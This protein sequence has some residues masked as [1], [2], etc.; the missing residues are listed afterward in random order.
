MEEEKILQQIKINKLEQF[1]EDFII[2]QLCVLNNKPFNEMKKV[3]DKLILQKRIFIKD[4]AV[5]DVMRDSSRK[6]VILK[7]NKG[8]VIKS[9]K[10]KGSKNR[11]DGKIAGTKKG[12]AFLVPF[13]SSAKD[14]FISEKNLN[15]AVNNDKV[16]IEILTDRK[17]RE[18]RVVQI[19]ERGNGS[20]VGKIKLGKVNAYVTPDDVKFG[21]DIF[22]PM[23]K[24]LGASD[25]DKVL[26]KVERYYSDRKLPDG[27][28]VE[29]L[30]PENDIKVQVL[31]CLRNYG[32][33]EGFPKKV[34]AAAIE[35][36]TIVDEKKYPH[37]KDR[38]NELIFTIDGADTRD[39]DDAIGLKKLKNG[40]YLLGVYIADVGEYVTR[41]RIIEDEAFKRGNSV[42]FPGLVLPML[43]KELSNG[44]CSLNPNVDR[45][46]LSVEMEIDKNGD[47]VN[48]DIFEGI[49]RSNKQFTYHEVQK[50]LDK[51]EN[52][53]KENSKFIETLWLMNELSKIL[54]NKRIQRGEITLDLPEAQIVLTETGDVSDI[55][56]QAHDDAHKLIESFMIA[57]NETIAT[58]YFL[59]KAPF[60]YRVHEKPDAE[61]V[62]NFIRIA[63][64]YGVKCN[65]SGENVVPKNLQKAL[66]QINGQDFA[67][68]L[69]RICLRSQKKAKY[70]PQCLGH[71]ALASQYYC[72]FT[73]PIRRY[74]DLTIH[75]IIKEDLHGQ[76][77]GRILAEDKQFVVASGFQSSDREVNAEEVE[78]EV[79]GLYK[80]LYMD[81]RIGE[82]FEANISSV[83]SFGI[84][85]ELENTVEG[86]VPLEELPDKYYTY[87]EENFM[88]VGQTNS[89]RLGDKI[90][91][92]CSAVSI[93]EHKINFSLV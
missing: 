12:Y 66:D 43:P 23:S 27:V 51:E 82:E 84:F 75:R 20:I 53:C 35:M 77:K 71:F 6:P 21:K 63:E 5:Q 8:T 33:F 62:D 15:G 85:V 37:R 93:S 72:H 19:L 67:F 80:A 41:G 70:M 9:A 42:Y 11:I 38:R 64:L 50:V 79:D 57:A 88:L 44:I 45:L 91:V 40:N 47:V 1:D 7:T 81:H 4:R 54:K 56:P 89:Y 61:K 49:I 73:S 76:L 69:N 2:A 10:N 30:G 13:D 78:R 90:K 18:G 28:V 86:L 65:F 29:V 55:Y 36:P 26:V 24:V 48:H 3:V 92:K 39:I 74:P 17:R 16:I 25:G 59:K 52:A 31:S 32:L 68:S 46:T 34:V 22:V 14:I 87:D 58:H 83:T 60:L